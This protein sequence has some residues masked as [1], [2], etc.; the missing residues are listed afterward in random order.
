MKVEICNLGAVNNASIELKP[1]TVFIG[2]N[3]TG[4][5]WMA[6]TLSAIFGQTGYQQYLKTYFDGKVTQTYP[7]E[8]I[9]SLLLEEGNAQIDLVQFANDYAEI[10]INEVARL[11]PNWMQ[12]LM[13][14]TRV[15]FEHL[16]IH[17]KLADAKT[18][19]LEK[20]AAATIEKKLSVGSL[21][22]EALLNALKESGKST[23]YFY[24]E[25]DVLKKLPHRAVT[26]FVST[27]IFQTL[28]QSI[29]S[30]VY[31]LPTERTGFIH[32]PL[33]IEEGIEQTHKIS[34]SS[35]V[36]RF[37]EM[38]TT[39]A[40]SSFA[41]REEQINNHPK[42]STYIKLAD[43]LENEILRGRVDFET[44]GSQKELL[45]QPIDNKNKLEI[46]V[47][48]GMVKELAP[49]V[50]CLRYLAQPNDWIII[51]EPEMNLHPAVQI[52]LIEFLGMLV[53]ADLQVLITT[54]SPY[55][56]DHLANLIT[57]AKHNDPDKIKKLFYLEQK[58]AFVPQEQVSIY[59]FDEGT[60][61]DAFDKEWVIDWRTFDNVFS[62]I[63]NIYPQLLPVIN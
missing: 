17:I 44:S 47:V 51:D 46:S 61:K 11:A 50:L 60:T 45:F 38:I 59:L 58:E 34:K 30:A 3:S 53:N 20:V 52:E 16:Q 48:S 24:S 43:F 55:F 7:L 26:K 1:L 31:I 9:V 19:F 54:H 39:T 63:A 18:A 6:Y 37:M 12:T 32:S 2:E 49:L 35:S 28:H 25:G 40:F 33:N 27:Q 4:K 5:T 62:D 15:N 57:A 14:T 21:R 8:N 29:Y 10:Y 23:L 56:V 36:K 42:I 41:E 13:A 22:Q